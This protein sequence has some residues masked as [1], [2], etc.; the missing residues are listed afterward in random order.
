MNTVVAHSPKSHAALLTTNTSRGIPDLEIRLTPLAP[1]LVIGFGVIFFVLGL[2]W[3]SPLAKAQ[4]VGPGALICIACTAAIVGG[5]YWRHHLPVMV[6]MTARQL[7]LPC[8]WPRHIVVDWNE[9]VAIEQV[10]YR[11]REVVRIKLSKPLTATDALS[12]AHAAYK[13]FNESLVKGLN[14]AVLNGYDI[15][16]NP[17]TELFRSAGWF[18]AEC[19]KRIAAAASA[20]SS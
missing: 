7:F 11:R 5:N 13:R 2:Y 18:V 4:N 12:Q 15:E 1:W 16:I 10:T 9:I 20:K 17:S 6:R 14:R 8:R 19:K 3:A